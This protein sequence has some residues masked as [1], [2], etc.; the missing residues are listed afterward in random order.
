MALRV[1]QLNCNGAAGNAQDVQTWVEASQ[2][3]VSL[4][5]LSETKLRGSQRIVW[6]K[7][8]FVGRGRVDRLGGGVGWLI[9]DS[10]AFRARPNLSSGFCESVWV[11]LLGRQPSAGVLMCSAYVPPC[12]TGEL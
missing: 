3:Q 5:A 1:L 2:V 4:V 12:S 7:W 11:E 8:A 9:R 10:V 6:D